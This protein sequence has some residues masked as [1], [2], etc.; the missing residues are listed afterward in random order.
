MMFCNTEN[1]IV[2]AEVRPAVPE[3]AE[4]ITR[5]VEVCYGSVCS[6]KTMTDA[7]AL[8]DGIR[9]GEMRI[10]LA[11]ETGGRILGIEACCIKEEFPRTLY[12][13]SK[14]THPA[15]RQFGIGREITRRFMR[16]IDFSGFDAAFAYALTYNDASQVLLNRYRFAVTGLVYNSFLKSEDIPGC[17]TPMPK[18]S[19]AVMVKNLGT[20]DAGRLYL[21]EM[22]HETARAVY[23]SLGVTAVFD[24]AGAPLCGRTVCRIQDIPEHQNTEIL[25]DQPGE[26]LQT[27]LEAILSVY[28]HRPL[29][30]YNVYLNIKEPSAVDAFRL[31]REKGFLC[32]GFQPLM[33]EREY[34]I[35][36]AS[37]RVGVF[38]EYY[39]VHP[40]YLPI[41]KFFADLAMNK[42]ENL[43]WW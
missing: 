42:E 29:Q 34:A 35:L 8:S 25:I 18:R 23:R 5:L 3:D 16:E 10:E 30:T 19:H 40:A 33:H 43:S 21:P 6:D 37:P 28:K 12:L 9:R 2:D 1:Q 36:Y 24:A 38:P 15:Y 14:M 26:D 13:K 17:T 32:S 41:K 39:Q 31:L 11:E 27:R 4:R 22:Y 20:A 7:P